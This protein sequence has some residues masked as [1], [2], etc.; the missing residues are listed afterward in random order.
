MHNN[1]C[2][3]YSVSTPLYC[4]GGG[5][6]SLSFNELHFRRRLFRHCGRAFFGFCMAIRQKQLREQT[7]TNNFNN[8]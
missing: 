1:C 5:Y 6:N 2:H 3:T 4:I 7:T 8:K